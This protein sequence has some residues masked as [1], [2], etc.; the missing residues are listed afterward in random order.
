MG[1]TSAHSNPQEQSGIEHYLALGHTPMMAQYHTLKDAHAGCL[2]FYRMGDFYELFYEDA[3]IA[4]RTLDITLTKRG[5]SN[6]DD[7]A[8]CGVPFHACGPYLAKLIRA[9]HKVA[10]CEQTETPDEAKARTKREGKPASKALV[11]REVVRIVTQGTLTED[12]L[13][14]AKS[15]NFLAAI[16]SHEKDYALAWVE[17]STGAFSVQCLAQKDITGA[18]AALNAG[19]ILLRED[20]AAALKDMSAQNPGLFTVQPNQMF[21]ISGAE[22]FLR[23]VFDVG[24]MESFGNF[25]PAET[26]ACGALVKYIERTQ[27][28]KIPHLTPP[29]Q[30]LQ[31]AVM[32]IDAATR[33][34]LELTRTTSGERSGS[35]LEAIDYTLT[36][37]GGRLLQTQLS[38][39]STHLPE[40]TERL[41]RIECLI[42]DPNLHLK[43]QDH[44]RATPDIERALGRLS[45]DRGGPRDLGVLMGGLVQAELI[46]AQLQI[47]E[48]ARSVFKKPLEF[49]SQVPQL[50][51]LQDT[52]KQAL[53]ET[54]P[55]LSRD[56]G[57][58]AKG[59]N[60]QLDNFKLLK[61]ESRRLIANL[62]EKYQSDTGIDK[63]KITFNNVL[64]YFIEVNAK[65]GDTLMALA[66]DGVSPYI[67][68]QTMANAVRFTTGELAE[69][70]RDITQASDKAL[71]LELEIFEALRQSVIALATPISALA[72]ALAQI[73]VAASHGA[74]AREMRYNRPELTQGLDFEI[75]GG[76]HPVVERALQKQS[77]AFVPNDSALGEGQRL[78]L[79]TGPN[80]AG[81]STFLRQNAL[82]GI[83]AQIG[84]FVPAQHARLGLIDKL[85]SRVGASDDLARG[86]S[87]FMVEMV[88]T[89]AILN[90]ATERS[91]VILDEIG[92]GT[93]TFDGLSIAWACVEYLHE[94]NKSRCI[95]A[96]HYHELTSLAAK[97]PNLA[98]HS[99]AVKEWKGDIVFM[100]S[101][102]K[103]AADRSYGIHVAKL[104]GIPTPVLQRAQ[105]VLAQLE[106][107][108]NSGKAAATL[109]NDLPLFTN[110]MQESKQNT[111]T[112]SQALATLKDLNPDTLSPREALD[113]LYRLKTESAD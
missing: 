112:P 12:D 78:W 66:K 7:I 64:G 46:R 105:Q 86:Q 33:R 104:A 113:M 20:L 98:C 6:G 63:L 84:S 109:T 81:K 28:G 67:H 92:R 16:A 68:R 43:L 15:N 42:N 22:E 91:L 8:M 11:N 94:A 49:L 44:L 69:L 58:I 25:S 24:S 80:M 52:L 95:F 110:A 9:G 107:G 27:K 21:E 54:Q 75:K 96:T 101:V 41:N 62:Q 90:Q 36:N 70:E 85:F 38:A 14:E 106:Q 13:L 31:N 34:S 108:G 53:S 4:A 103:G 88:E 50:A 102:T 57:F 73:D 48:T 39:P 40:I 71:A 55:M 51:A 87:T 61:D 3:E 45:A 72:G 93:A 2:L 89:A 74:L 23:Q 5:K 97:L 18:L 37:A 100:H 29:R 47:D 60:A 30:V 26:A 59:F 32:H 10:V 82:I 77:A 1:Q 99:M 83:L 17:L 56:G 76:R 79:L 35:L 111:F 19:E 65:N